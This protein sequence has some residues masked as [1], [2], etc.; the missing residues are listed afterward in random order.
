MRQILLTRILLGTLPTLSLSVSH[1]LLLFNL[2]LRL[3]HIPGTIRPPYTAC[4][5]MVVV[6]E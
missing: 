5:G 4:S 6:F 3:Q 1:R 2:A